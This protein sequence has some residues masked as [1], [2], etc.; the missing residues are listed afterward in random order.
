[1]TARKSYSLSDSQRRAVRHLS[2][3]L[4]WYAP[5]RSWTTG[6]TRCSV[7]GQLPEPARFIVAVQKN[8]T[9]ARAWIDRGRGF[10]EYNKR[11]F[12]ALVGYR[13][14]IDRAIGRVLPA[15]AELRWDR[16]DA[17]RR[18]GAVPRGAAIELRLQLTEADLQT[19][20][21]RPALHAIVTFLEAVEEPVRFAV[22]SVLPHLA[23]DPP[24]EG[25]LRS[26][27]AAKRSR[28]PSPACTAAHPDAIE[29]ISLFDDLR[30]WRMLTLSDRDRSSGKIPSYRAL[31]L[32]SERRP[33]T[34]AEL[35][36]I[37]GVSQRAVSEFGA[38]LLSIV[39]Q[40]QTDRCAECGCFIEV[41]ASSGG[42]RITSCGG[43]GI[44]VTTTV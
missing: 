13:D 44:R 18:H 19:A 14:Q 33:R 2:R 40:Y 3:G 42:R 38:A 36:S 6:R 16:K 27:S 9:V 26:S 37:S 28:G 39:G 11:V 32:L 31:L 43:C 35:A 8:T 7:Y 29:S 12:D 34:A 5:E 1:M 20:A 4:R 10:G 41:L 30:R 15:G 25:T 17:P 21:P 22:S 23:I 24:P